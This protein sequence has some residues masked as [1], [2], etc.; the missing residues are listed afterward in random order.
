MLVKVQSLTTLA[1]SQQLKTL[2]KTRELLTSKWDTM[3]KGQSL[4]RS[5]MKIKRI[6]LKD[7]KLT[8]QLNTLKLCLKLEECFQI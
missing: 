1:I 6:K 2:K 3:N 5:Q 8:K 7:S 4:R